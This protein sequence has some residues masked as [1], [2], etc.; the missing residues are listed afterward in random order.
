MT[1]LKANSRLSA[2]KTGRWRARSTVVSALLSHNLIAAFVTA[3][4][5]AALALNT[6]DN[7]S[8]P[9]DADT[10]WLATV[11]DNFTRR[12]FK[13]ESVSPMT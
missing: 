4:S 5:P 3:G 6:P 8:I 9:S 10:V 2:A 13:V 11:I 7:A 12:L 1:F